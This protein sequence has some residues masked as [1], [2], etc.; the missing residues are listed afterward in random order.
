MIKLYDFA[1]SGNCHKVR[2]MLAML[3][4][5]YER[6]NIDLTKRDQM[7]D[8]FIALNPLHKVP[9]LEHRG[10]VLRDSSAILLYL[11]RQYGKH[12]WAPAEPREAAMIQQ[13]LSLSVNEVFNGL[14]MARAIIIFK[15]EMD[16]TAAAVIAK[17][18]LNVMEDRLSTHEWLALDRFTIADLAC[19]PYAALAHEGHIDLSPF[20]AIRVWFRR[21]EALPGY[22]AMRGLPHPQ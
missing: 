7:S 10:L 21:I 20:P 22:V 17:T 11:A 14:A 6:V 13:W 12:E 4:L 2:M 19:Y 5:E 8:W 3:G 9:V 1:L 15:R 16:H 18:A